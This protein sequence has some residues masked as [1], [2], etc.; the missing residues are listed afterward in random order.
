MTSIDSRAFWCCSRLTSIDIPNSVTDIGWGAFLDCSRLTAIKIPNSVTSIGRWAFERCTGLTSINIP[1]SVTSIEDGA[2]EGCTNLTLIKVDPANP[3]YDSRDNCNAIIEKSI[4][5]V[6]SGCKNTIISSSVTSIGKD[7]FRGCSG[8]T[9]IKI[10]N[11]V[12]SIGEYAFEGCSSLES[13]TIPDSV[14]SIGNYAFYDCK[15][16]TSVSIPN[17][18]TSIGSWAFCGCSS[19][20]SITIPNSVKSIGHSAFS[21]CSSLASINVD[22]GNST[23][24][25]RGNCNAIIE[26][27]FN[28]LITGCK[29]TTIPDSVT[30]I[31]KGAFYGCTRLEKI[32]IP[33]SIK[34]IEIDAFKDCPSTIYLTKFTKHANNS[35]DKITKVVIGPVFISYSWDDD[36]HVKWVNKF[37]TDLVKRGVYVIFDQWDLRGGNDKNQFMEQSVSKSDVVLCILTP[38][39]K[40]KCD[41]RRGGAGY[42]F[43]VIS[44]EIVQD[45]PSTKFIPILRTGDFKSSSPIGIGSKYGFDFTSNNSKNYYVLLKKLIS[46][47][48]EESLRPN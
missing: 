44:Q 41:G 21:G 43:S 7:A 4:N 1:N 34:Y 17:S 32:L 9:S 40:E 20:T 27:S 6:I 14:T 13:V 42:E 33:K 3:V 25:S 15:G 45:N 28:T 19:L 5:T 24:D 10:P 46:E 23:Y 8:L 12:T 37:A 18:V 48:K 35:F 39:Y 31:G 2:F 26:T 22:P 47:I 30:I 36:L 11:S 16:L 38:N 29:N